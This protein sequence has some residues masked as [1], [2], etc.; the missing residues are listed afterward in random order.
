M[1]VVMYIIGYLVLPI[2][3]VAGVGLVIVGYID[4]RDGLA[5]AGAVLTAGVLVAATKKSA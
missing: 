2:S 3:A 4:R 5:I 1:K